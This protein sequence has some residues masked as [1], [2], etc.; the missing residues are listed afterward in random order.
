MK[1]AI[2]DFDGTLFPKDTL[3]FL[4]KEWKRQKYS[5]MKYIKAYSSLI[6]LYIKYKSGIQSKLSKED[7][8]IRAVMKFNR[9]FS[10]MTEK[11]VNK[12]FC[13][14]SKVI[15]ELLNKAVVEEVHK[16][17]LE[18]YHTVLLSGAHQPLLEDLGKS[19]DIDTVIGT[20][21]YFNNGIINL[22]KELEITCGLMKVKRIKDCFKD[23]DIDWKNSKSYADS[24]SDLHILKI[25]GQPIVVNPDKQLKDI[26][27]NEKWNVMV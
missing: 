13:N 7:M 26:A 20:N 2:F 10:G 23:R 18:G 14:C 19:L 8:K 5:R 11:E 15:Q 1:L 24:Y 4:L 27:N 3:P 9:L 16:A 17:R 25:V 6:S 22:E 21:L 12:F